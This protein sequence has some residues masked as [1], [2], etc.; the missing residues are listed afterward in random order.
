VSDSY[1]FFRARASFGLAG[2]ACQLPPQNLLIDLLQPLVLGHPLLRH[3]TAHLW[4]LHGLIDPR[5]WLHAEEVE[6]PV[7]ALQPRFV[8]EPVQ[9]GGGGFPGKA[10][11]NQ[12]TLN[13]TA[14]RLPGSGSV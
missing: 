14:G 2:S 11:D 10:H 12:V 8:S 3:Q 9:F 1:L 6:L 5:G 7:A 13:N 4:N